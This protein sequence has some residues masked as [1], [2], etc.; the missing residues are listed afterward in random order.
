MCKY[1]WLVPVA[2]AGLSIAFPIV[3][4]VCVVLI[5]GVTPLIDYEFYHNL[6]K[7]D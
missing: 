5:C 1:L 7:E 6:N 3:A 2:L 4:Q